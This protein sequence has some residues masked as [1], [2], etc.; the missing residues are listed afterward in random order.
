MRYTIPAIVFTLAVG[1]GSAPDRPSPP[2]AVPP[3][4]VPAQVTATAPPPGT[5]IAPTPES[6]TATAPPPRT[7]TTSAPE[8]PT[9]YGTLADL[10][11]AVGR[12]TQA[13]H[14]SEAVAVT[15]M[16]GNGQPS[17]TSNARAS[18][19]Q[20]DTGPASVRLVTQEPDPTTGAPFINELVLLPDEA[21]VRPDRKNWPEPRPPWIRLDPAGGDQISQFFAPIVAR[22]QQS[23]GGIGCL[24]DTG[25]ASIVGVTADRLDGVDVLRYDL[26]TRL[27][28]TAT[29]LAT[30]QQLRS[31]GLS[32]VDSAVYVDSADRQLRCAQDVTFPDGGSMVADQR[33]VSYAEPLTI[34]APPA[35]QVLWLPSGSK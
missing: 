17:R 19:I 16:T 27:D 20:H 35:D 24:T 21:Y 23:Q 1:C 13:D 11:A 34:E 29:D 12:R 31:R 7:S 26:R 28:D 5:S 9:R 22:Q 2:V 32:T 10:V 33:L 3:A 8:S 14:T 18:V 4:A 25:T 15:R 30:S 6:P